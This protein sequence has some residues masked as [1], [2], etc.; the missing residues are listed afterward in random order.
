MQ[1][2]R[3]IVVDVEKAVELFKNYKDGND[4]QS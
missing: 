2:G 4:K 1:Q 3:K